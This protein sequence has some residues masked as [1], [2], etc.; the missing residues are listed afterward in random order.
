MGV[1]K[2]YAWGAMTYRIITYR[3]TLAESDPSGFGLQTCL[4]NTCQE[5]IVPNEPGSFI[6]LG[7]NRLSGRGNV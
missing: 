5:S 7:R 3:S 6:A 1:A 2:S 4:T